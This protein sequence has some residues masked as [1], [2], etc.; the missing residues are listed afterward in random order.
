[1]EKYL[2][3]KKVLFIGIGFYDYDKAIKEEIEKAGA[4]VDYFQEFLF[5]FKSRI[6]L[7][8]NNKFLDKS[9]IDRQKEI[10]KQCKNNY[11]YVFVIKGETLKK[12]F[13]EGLRNKNKNAKFI[14]YQ[15]DSIRRVE[16]YREIE[17]YFDRKLSFDRIDT[18]NEKDLAFLPLFY[19]EIPR[20]K[21]IINEDIDVSFVG[22]Y[23]S[24]RYEMCRKIA[25]FSQENN[26][27]SF[28]YIFTGILQYT[29]IRY[30]LYNKEE[31]KQRI[32]QKKT[33]PYKEFL[34]I[35]NRSKVVFDLAHPDQNG[36]TMR[37]I[38]LVAR[39]KKIITNNKDIINYNFY[40]K[41]NIFIHHEELDKSFLDFLTSKAEVVDDLII[42]KYSIS[43]WVKNIFNNNLG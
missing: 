32:I 4:S 8:F 31:N 14:M 33:L 30:F 22:W 38:E 20:N 23:H 40:N 11:D 17:G 42:K 37:T 39:G 7:K 24:D 35:V 43:N 18:L 21:E 9:K 25:K 26:I 2:I 36:L 10:L 19:R 41:N 29:K 15:W 16:N 3:G 28:L 12:I 5:T 13:L 27:K 1:M 6:F 34:D